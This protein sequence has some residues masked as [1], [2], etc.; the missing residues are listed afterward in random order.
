[1][2]ITMRFRRKRRGS[3]GGRRGR[4]SFSRRRSMKRRGTPRLRIGYRM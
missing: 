2:E 1:M 3:R 4:R